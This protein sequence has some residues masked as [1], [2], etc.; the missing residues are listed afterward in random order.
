[1][2]L[3]IGEKSFLAM[4]L[5]PSTLADLWRSCPALLVEGLA[6]EA[7]WMYL[8]KQDDFFLQPILVYLPLLAHGS[9]IGGVGS[10]ERLLSFS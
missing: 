8:G 2:Y 9:G 4:N 10:S 5:V 1:V 7:E 6:E 3:L